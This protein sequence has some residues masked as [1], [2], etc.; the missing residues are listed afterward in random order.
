MYANVFAT[1]D[2]LDGVNRDKIISSYSGIL[3]GSVQRF[4]VVFTDFDT[5]PLTYIEAGSKLV[6]NVPRAFKD[7]KVIDAETS[8]PGILIVPG[9]EPTVVIHPDETTQI[10]ASVPDRI[11]DVLV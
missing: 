9:I 6:V 4:S 10:I 5:D 3:S 2:W 11:W 7:V 1:T 8:N